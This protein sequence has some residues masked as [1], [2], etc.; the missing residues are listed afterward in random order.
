MTCKLMHPKAI[1]ERLSLP[2]LCTGES[3]LAV[4][5]E[6]GLEKAKLHQPFLSE[7]VDHAASI[8]AASKSPHIL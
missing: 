4:E 5:A 7:A 2:S 3:G 8:D 6:S 1:D